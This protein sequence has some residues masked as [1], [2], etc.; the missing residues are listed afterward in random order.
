M[1]K[2]PLTFSELLQPQFEELMKATL[3]TWARQD[4]A[5]VKLLKLPELKT[6]Q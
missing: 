3:E 6:D 1:E 4:E 2:K 5:W